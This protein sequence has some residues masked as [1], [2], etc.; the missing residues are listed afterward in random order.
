MLY[1]CHGRNVNSVTQ[2]DLSDLFP[3]FS[4]PLSENKLITILTLKSPFRD[5][6]QSL[7]T[8]EM[9]G[10]RWEGFRLSYCY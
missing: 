2:K 4:Q 7:Q 1:C 10:G 3:R 6:L 5:N 8:T 9:K